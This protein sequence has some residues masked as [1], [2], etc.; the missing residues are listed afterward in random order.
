M[1]DTDDPH[2]T[3]D[4]LRVILR[5]VKSAGLSWLKLEAIGVEQRERLGIQTKTKPQN[6]EG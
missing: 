6:T 1:N 4:E 2:F 3:R 5:S